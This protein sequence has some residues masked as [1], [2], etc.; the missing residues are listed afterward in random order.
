SLREV[1]VMSLKTRFG[2]FANVLDRD[3]RQPDV[4]VLDSPVL[5]NGEWE[6][7][8]SHFGENAQVIDCTFP[9][10]S[11]HDG[12]KE[13]I[14]R[15]RAE[16]ER[17]V[18]SGKSQLFLTDEFISKTRVALPMILAAAGVH[19]SLVRKGLRTFASI[20]VRSAECLDTHYFAVL[21]GV[22]STTVNAYLAQ[23]AIADRHRRGLFGSLTLEKCVANY[24]K[25]INDGLLK[26]MAKMG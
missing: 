25:A 20:N 22:G 9:A 10:G 14:A 24:R 13:A 11:G 5:T 15:I 4:M 7:L 12:L 1:G 21:I 8:L 19:T 6:A 16:A 26:I 17:A 2:N 3:A 18:R 23:E